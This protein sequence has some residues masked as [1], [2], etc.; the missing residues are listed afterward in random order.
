MLKKLNYIFTRQQKIKLLILSMIIFI[1][2][3]IE[4]IG[5]S[6]IMP[7]I[8]VITD[9]SVL[10]RED[11][12]R[13]L[14]NLFQI[15]SAREFVLFFTIFLIGVYLLKN[16]YVLFQNSLQYR[17]VYN[18]QRQLSTRMM[19]CY[20]QQDY[21]YHVS[22]GVAE[23][24]RNVTSDVSHFY[25][26]VLALTQFETEA[27]VCILLV[28]YLLYSSFSF[29]ISIVLLLGISG[30]L[31]ILL[32]RKYTVRFGAQ[33]RKLAG[34]QNKWIIQAFTGIK[35]I[36]VMNKESYFLGMYDESYRQSTVVQRKNALLG[37]LPKPVIEA[38]SICGVLSIIAVRTYSGADLKSFI[39]ILSVFAVSMFRML[40]S[41]NRL[42][43]YTNTILYG[44]A[45]VDNVYKDLK[46]IDELL[47]NKNELVEDHCIFNLKENI[48]L[49]NISF[50]Y[51][52][53]D[54]QVLKNVT[55][56]IPSHKSVALIGPSGAGKT[57]LAD[58][59]LG[60]LI[61]QKGKIMVGENNVFEHV[62]SWHKN[63]GYI[64]QM[65]F[66][67]NDSLRNNVAFG[68]EEEDIDDKK[69]W[70]ALRAAQLDKFVESLPEG[71]DTQIGDRGVK[72]SGGQRQRIGIARALYTDPELL[73]LDEATSA[74]DNETETA[75]MEA[76]D[77]L[78]GSRT[79][80]IIAHRL[81]TIKNCDLIYEICDQ[82]AHLR[83][84]EDVLN[85]EKLGT[86]KLE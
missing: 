55:L 41:F 2:S 35:E 10:E 75:V 25:N 26:V 60:I 82:N 19:N 52:G 27:L 74:L 72:L 7:L 5:V 47:K 22:N 11:M 34:L 36:K 15:Q 18:N 31:F 81:T 70:E 13:W 14:G 67:M 46:E 69:I 20:L 78:H 54:K 68:I 42:S 24:Q 17:F 61:P 63:I 49:E 16:I 9:E 71:L 51:P 28:L 6:A 1:G 37:A 85:W 77:S 53:S 44:K 86:A 45:A 38:L 3:F 21:L 32:Y 76:I 65:I 23:L 4:L 64:P 66:L 58:I 8:T 43:G 48:C 39:P 30:V 79:L 73:I 29:T 80:V 62:R 33:Y 56:T 40:P 84:K 59:L 83:E 50:Q 57:T 12:Y